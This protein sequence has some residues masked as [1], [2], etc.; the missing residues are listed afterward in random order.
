MNNDDKK[1]TTTAADDIAVKG[2]FLW[3]IAKK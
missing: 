2:Y 1:K 3:N